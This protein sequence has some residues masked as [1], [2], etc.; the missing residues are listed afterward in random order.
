M[1]KIIG[2][3]VFVLLSTISWAQ[4]GIGTTNPDASAVLEV[5][6]TT[7]GVLIPRMTK[8]QMAA[9]SPRVEGLM[10]YCTDCDIKS[11]YVYD[12]NNYISLTSGGETVANNASKKFN[13]LMNYSKY[14][15][16]HL[17]DFKRGRIVNMNT[18]ILN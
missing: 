16:L 2:F 6:S 18:P 15:F 4:V 14:A 5:S 12:G 13:L 3:V 8:T 11:L 9:I 17:P 10:M 7:K 1:K